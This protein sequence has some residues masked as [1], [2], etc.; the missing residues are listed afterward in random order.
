MVQVMY[1]IFTENSKTGKAYTKRNA[2]Q[3]LHFA[4]DNLLETNV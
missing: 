4:I 2:L 1:N 3:N